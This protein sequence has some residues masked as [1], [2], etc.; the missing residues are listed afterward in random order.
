MIIIKK[1]YLLSM[2]DVNYEFRDIMINDQ[3]KIEAIKKNIDVTKYPKAKEIK[4]SGKYV[5]PGLVD[6]HCHIGVSEEVFR[7]GDDT[8]EMTDPITPQLRGL[9]GINMHDGAFTSAL[10]SGITCVN[11][12][13]GSANGIGGTFSVLKLGKKRFDDMVMIKESAMKMALGENPKRVY[14]S[15]GKAPFTRMATAA[16]I[17]EQL[18]KAKNYYEKVEAAKKDGSPMPEFNQKLDS[19]MR[20]YNGLPVK[21]HA[22]RQ[23]DIETAIRIMEEFDLKGSI[24]HCTE[25]YMIADILKEKNIKCIIGPTM[26]AKSKPEV[27]NKTYDAGKI[28]HDNGVEFAIMTDHPVTELRDTLLQVG[29]YVR[30]GLSEIDALKAV[31]INAAKLSYVS[32]RVGSIEV[33]KDA[34]IVIWTH[35]PLHHLAQPKYIMV[36]GEIVYK[37]K[38]PEKEKKK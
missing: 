13:P 25:G 27:Q 8:N 36:D 19:L 9:D 23:D 26:H 32:D 22:H 31:T 12:G 1:A 24:E 37:I 6:A 5:T 18:Q 10:E 16:L 11:T 38:K 17:R 15:K 28:L 14:G 33:G 21:I 4:A 35:M 29:R 34:D 20:V 7:E 2:A 30:A 3:G